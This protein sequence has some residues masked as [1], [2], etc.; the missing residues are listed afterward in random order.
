MSYILGVET[1][2][3]EVVL[4]TEVAHHAPHQRCL[5]YTCM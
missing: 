1:L 2:E 3:A 4:L 5:A